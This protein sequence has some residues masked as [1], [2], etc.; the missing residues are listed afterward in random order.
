MRWL[1]M[2]MVLAG[3][4]EENNGV[5]AQLDMAQPVQTVVVATCFSPNEGCKDLMV[6]VIDNAQSTVRFENYYFTH[7]DIAAALIRAK[8]RSI[9]VQGILDKSQLTIQYSQLPELKAGNIPVHIDSS[10]PT[11]HIKALMV[12]DVFCV[13][14]FN[15]T[16]TADTGNAE[17][18]IC[19]RDAATFTKYQSEYI[20]HE[21]HSPL[22]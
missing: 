21:A 15:F 5:V 2:V 22:Y 8:N 12:D 17:T 18:M 20:V 3:C 14:S 11:F 16:E 10:H 7:P 13:G 6:H 9:D 19:I 1:C 4:M